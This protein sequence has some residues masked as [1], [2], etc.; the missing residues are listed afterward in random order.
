MFKNPFK[1]K[2]L[3]QDLQLI[4]QIVEKFLLNPSVKKLISPLS[5]EYLLIDEEHSISVCISGGNIKLANHAFVLVKSVHIGFTEKLQKLI[6]QQI[7][8]ERQELKKQLFK[9]EINLLEKI[10]SL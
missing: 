10:N 5:G 7:E 3:P 1:K 9:N 2:P 4:Q 8:K 6:R